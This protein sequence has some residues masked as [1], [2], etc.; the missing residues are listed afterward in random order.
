M[1]TTFYNENELLKFILLGELRI[2]TWFT[3]PSI[4]RHKLGSRTM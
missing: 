4:Q 2:T 1:V 3:N